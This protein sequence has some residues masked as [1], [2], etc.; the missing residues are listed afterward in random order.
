MEPKKLPVQSVEHGTRKMVNFDGKLKEPLN[1]R[2]HRLTSKSKTKA[3]K[4][5]YM[6]GT[7]AAKETTNYTPKH[8]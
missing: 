7:K 2:L 5:E 6:K 4:G 3:L 8:Q 1:V